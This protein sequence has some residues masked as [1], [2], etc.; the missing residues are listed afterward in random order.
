[1]SEPVSRSTSSRDT[2]RRLPAALGY[3][4]CFFALGLLVAYLN[5]HH[6]EQ[7]SNFDEYVKMAEHYLGQA[8]RAVLTYPTWGYPFLLMALPRYDLVAAP[9]MAFAALAATMLLLALHEQVPAHRRAITVLFVIGLPW[10]LVHSVKWP[11]SVSTSFGI[12][13]CVLLAKALGTGNRRVGLAAGAV[14]GLALYFRSEFLYFPLFVVV[15]VLLARLVPRLRDTARRMFVGPGLICAVAAWI[16]LVPWAIHYHRETGRYSLTASQRGIVAFISLA[17]LPDNPWGA[18]YLDEYAYDYL[19]ERG[20]TAVA[21][22]DS[23]DRVLY[24][25][26][27]R[28]VREHPGAFAKK[29]VWNGVRTALGGF[30]NGEI[31]LTAA[32]NEQLGLLRERLK[33]RAVPALA[34]ADGRAAGG[35]ADTAT[36][37]RVYVAFA[38]WALAKAVG[39]LFVIISIAGLIVVLV[40]GFGSPLVFVLAAY[41]GYQLVLLLVLA[42][43]PRHLNG[44]YLAMIPFFLAAVTPVTARARRQFFPARKR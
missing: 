12:I 11:Q 27:K 33:A 44:L 41:I 38:Y 37:P 18:V 32:E 25:E 40:R 28:R 6:V 2:E 9:Q 20:I 29:M 15:C 39:A 14:A 17:Q 26:F 5:R 1:M 16:A 36:S 22:S 42:T 23:G 4:V 24:D 19:T 8:R 21:V 3:F 35:S 30:Y 34:A 31:P 10:Y 13:A 7:Q 43:D